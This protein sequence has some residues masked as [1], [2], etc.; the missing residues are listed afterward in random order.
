M[1]DAVNKLPT[2]IE[3][4]E[5]V[6]DEDGFFYHPCL[7]DDDNEFIPIAWFTE[8]GIETSA[9]EME[10]DAT[11]NEWDRYT[12]TGEADCSYWEPSRP[13]GDGWFILMIGDTEDGPQCVW[14]RPIAKAENE[15]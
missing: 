8:R 11:P 13:D 12:E 14:G 15:Q 9:A 2:L 3:P 4:A 10:Y 1:S 6:R 5:V 7:P